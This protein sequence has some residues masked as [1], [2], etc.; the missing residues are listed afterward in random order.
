MVGQYVRV[1]I[2]VALTKISVLL[3]SDDVWAFSIAFDG[4]T[5]RSIAFFDVHIRIVVKGI[6]YNFHL[7]AMPHFDRHT[8]DL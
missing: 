5:H 7:I 6:L 8:A 2:S 4:N 1:L 3:S